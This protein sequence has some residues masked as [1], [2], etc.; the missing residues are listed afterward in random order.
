MERIIVIVKAIK[1][2]LCIAGMV[3]AILTA[4]T[5]MTAC[6]D[7]EGETTLINT[8]WKL[9]G[10][11]NTNDQTIR[12]PLES[13]MYGSRAYTVRFSESGTISGLACF[14]ENMGRYR[15]WGDSIKVL[16]FGGTKVGSVSPYLEEEDYY[17]FSFMN[18]STF[19]ISNRQL[20][21]FY[22]DGKEYMLFNRWS[23][24]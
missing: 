8:S 6:S 7:D 1:S 2:R 20:K 3:L 24:S 16:S 11:G 13:P 10:Y 21:L 17:K 5:G 22:N 12:E 18:C 23:G 4:V 15:V 19:E 14:N 9:Q